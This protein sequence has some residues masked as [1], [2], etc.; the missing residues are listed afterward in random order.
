VKALH[1]DGGHRVTEG[2]PSVPVEVLGLSELPA[3]GDRLAVVPDEK[4]ARETVAE[5][6]RRKDIQ[7]TRG[8][9]LE[10][11]GARISTGQVKELVLVVKTDVHGSTE[12]V[13]QGLDQLSND[14]TQVRVI[15]A[16]TGAITETDVL[17][18]VASQA[19]I[20]G[21]NVGTEQG[22]V[23]LAAQDHVDIRHYNIIYRLTEDIQAALAGMLEPSMQDVTEGKAEVRAIFA[24]G[25]TRKTAGCYV[26]GGKVSR[27]AMARVFRGE[28]LLFDGPVGSLRRFK[29]DV[30]EVLTGYECGMTVEGFNAYEIGDT[31][32]VH[33]QQKVTG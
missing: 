30:R 25:R 10:E 2:G 19:I 9:T 32:E 20:V 21:F 26:L 24:M 28:Q 12:A 5:I 3:A 11:L 17:L 22:A 13:R 33:R 15:H 6:K 23:R 16:A 31:I 8:A 27:G 14:V 18:A 1:D 4:T 29:D 7:R